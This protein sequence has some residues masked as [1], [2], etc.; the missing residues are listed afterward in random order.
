[1]VIVNCKQCNGEF[2]AYPLE[3][4]RGRGKFCSRKCY[5]KWTSKNVIGERHPCWKSIFVN[6]S[7]CKTSFSVKPSEIKYGWGKF[8]SK[9]CQYFSYVG[10][11]V[12][13][14]SPTWKGGKV[15]K[16]CLS[17]DKKFQTKPDQIKRG[18]GKFCSN[19]CKNQWQKESGMY[20]G[21]NNPSWKGGRTPLSK[22][23]RGS[24]KYKQWI[25][26]VFNR[27]NFTCQICNIRGGELRANHIKKFSDYPK[28]RTTLINGITI[29]ESCD[30]KFVMHHEEDCE[31]FF[32]FNLIERGHLS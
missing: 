25:K 18:W 11:Y 17:C 14:N 13:K 2:K 8:C 6:C 19:R 10:K 29:C 22:I 4:E 9:E 21:C 31:D 1:M 27:D 26:S 16:N 32:N 20:L 12:G 15:T 7:I 24:F 28:L 5:A 3:I 30:L 23:I